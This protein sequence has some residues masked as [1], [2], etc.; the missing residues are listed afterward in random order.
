MCLRFRQKLLSDHGNIKA[1]IEF[2][3]I[4]WQVIETDTCWSNTVLSI[5]E[6][7]A[8]AAY[9]INHRLFTVWCL[10]RYSTLATWLLGDRGSVLREH[11]GR[12]GPCR[13]CN[14]SV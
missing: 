4:T 12:A 3:S 8:H 6:E 5:Y 11:C 10:E 1:R 2:N 7:I 13:S 9:I 14:C